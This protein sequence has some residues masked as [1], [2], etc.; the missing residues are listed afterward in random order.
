MKREYVASGRY[1]Y[2]GIELYETDENGERH[3]Q[4]TVITGIKP[5]KLGR[6]I[7]RLLNLAYAYGIEDGS[8]DE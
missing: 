8:N 2:T 6:E 3:C 4:R 1:G 5:N 7:A